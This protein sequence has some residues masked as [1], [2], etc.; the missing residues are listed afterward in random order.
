MHQ[1]TGI[2]IRTSRTGI[3]RGILCRIRAVMT[4]G[5]GGGHCVHAYPITSISFRTRVTTHLRDAPFTRQVS[6]SGTTHSRAG[7]RRAVMAL[8]THRALFFTAKSSS[9]RIF[10][11]GTRKVGVFGCSSGAIMPGFTLYTSNQPRC[12]TICARCA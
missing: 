2:R 4:R 7:T 12:L 10:T 1:T 11:S 6:T 8:G 3:L 5:A 9:G